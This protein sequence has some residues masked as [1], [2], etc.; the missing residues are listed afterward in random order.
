MG[1]ARFVTYDLLRFPKGTLVARYNLIFFT[2]FISGCLHI[3]IDFGRNSHQVSQARYASSVSKS[4]VSCSRM[5]RKATYPQRKSDFEKRHIASK[6]LWVRVVSSF[7]IV[8]DSLLAVFGNQD[9]EKGGCRYRMECIA[10]FGPAFSGLSQ[11]SIVNIQ[12]N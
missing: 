12:R 7:P 1:L 2:F 4:W 9:R 11:R 6:S 10:F 3:I 5:E 8:V